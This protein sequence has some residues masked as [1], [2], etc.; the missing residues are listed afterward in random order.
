[1]FR[2]AKELQQAINNL[3]RKFYQKIK[4]VP[5]FGKKKTASKII[6]LKKL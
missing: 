3:D 5:S 1:M 4:V 2:N 6:K